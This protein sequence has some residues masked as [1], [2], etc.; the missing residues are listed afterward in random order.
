MGPLAALLLAA[1]ATP[2]GVA[3]RDARELTQ[4]LV[5]AW[6]DTEAASFAAE[7][8]A[9]R[10]VE[11]ARDGDAEGLRVRGDVAGLHALTIRA[12]TSVRVTTSGARSP[13]ALTAR[14]EGEVFRLTAQPD[15]PGTVPTL[16]AA[17]TLALSDGAV[18]RRAD[19]YACWVSR[20]KDG[21]GWTFTPDLTIREG[22][23]VT[24]PDEAGVS[25]PAA[26][27]LRHVRWPSGPN[28]DSLVLYVHDEAEAPAVSYAWTAPDAA[29]IAINL[30]WVQASCTREG[31]E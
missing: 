11:I 27:R 20:K 1:Q 24:L 5:G 9:P 7:A 19:P 12:D 22:E 31:T 8:R 26:L 25:R 14:R 4:M 29:R 30:R 2:E 16:V 13:C 28:R 15:C 17:D 18:M 3:E 6:N 21:D 10:R 23:T